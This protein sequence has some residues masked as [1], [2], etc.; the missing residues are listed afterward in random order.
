M[1][2]TDNAPDQAHPNQVTAL[3]ALVLAVPAALA[4][5]EKDAIRDCESH[6]RSEYP[7]SDLRD[8]SAEKILDSEH[9]YQVHGFAKL[10]GDKFGEDITTHWVF[11]ILAPIG[12]PSL[13]WATLD[14]RGETAAYSYGFE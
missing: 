3:L 7:L 5:G 9:H 13:Q 6:I 14:P 10:D 11:R 2:S 8:A 12:W 1:E 4:Y